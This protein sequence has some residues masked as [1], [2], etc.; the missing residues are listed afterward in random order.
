MRLSTVADGR[1]NNFN[2]IR[3]LAALTVLIQH[4]TPTATGV[5]VKLGRQSLGMTPASVAVDVFFITSG[6]LVTSS[7]MRSGRLRDFALARGVRIFPALI[8][9]V[10]LTVFVLGPLFTTLPLTAY[11]NNFGTA[12]YLISGSTAIFGVTAT[13]PGVF[14]TNPYESVVNAPLWTLPHELRMYAILGVTWLFCSRGTQGDDLSTFRRSIVCLA[15]LGAILTVSYELTSAAPSE[16][17]FRMLFFMFFQGGAL[18]IARDRIILCFPAFLLAL[19][20]LCLSTLSRPAFYIAYVATLAYMVLYLAYVPGRA[21]RTYNR[22]GDY[23]YGTYITGFPIEQVIAA[24]IPGI[25]NIRMILMATPVT[26]V[27][28]AVS[29]HCIER[30]ALRLKKRASTATRSRPASEPSHNIADR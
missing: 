1:D 29:W 25:S 6:F 27:V 7:L 24:L 19:G 2:L 13:L 21:I 4:A 9:V 11:F 8:T 15:C 16:N 23:S 18:F 20:T 10:V 26:I 22:V 28:A 14:G 17:G 12:R 30:H 5:M 3:I